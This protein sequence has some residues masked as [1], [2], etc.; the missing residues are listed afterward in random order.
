M[1]GTQGSL[2]IFC[3]TPRQGRVHPA[4]DR[5]ADVRVHQDR[6]QRHQAGSR[7]LASPRPPVDAVQKAGHGRG[8]PPGGQDF[9]PPLPEVIME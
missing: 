8:M 6:P 5:R 1:M 7:W 9:S 4:V 3:V 2:F